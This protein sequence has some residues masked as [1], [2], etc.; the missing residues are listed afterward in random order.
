MGSLLLEYSRL[1]RAIVSSGVPALEQS[2]RPDFLSSSMFRDAHATFRDR[3]KNSV[4][5]E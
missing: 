3:L 5:S 1:F 4:R 2:P